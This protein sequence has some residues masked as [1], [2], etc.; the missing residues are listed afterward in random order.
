MVTFLFPA[1]FRL[2]C[3]TRHLHP[4]ILTCCLFFF[5]TECNEKCPKGTFEAS[6]CN[7][8]YPVVCKSKSYI[9]F[10]LGLKKSRSSDSLQEKT[11]HIC[12]SQLRARVHFVLA[13]FQIPNSGCV[14][15]VFITYYYSTIASFYHI[16]SRERAKYETVIHG[17]VP[18]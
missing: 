6:P 11:K 14:V 13:S 9:L 12:H 5:L 15:W 17:S 7:R 3:S 1:S 8:T 10:F 16:W 2:R 4:Q 18:V